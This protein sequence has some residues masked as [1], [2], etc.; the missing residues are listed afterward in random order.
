MWRVAEPM[1]IF[2]NSRSGCSTCKAKR[3]KCDE[4]KPTCKQCVKRKVTCG[5]YKKD[6]KWRAF[7]DASP[8]APSPNTH[9]KKGGWSQRGESDSIASP[10]SSDHTNPNTRSS[11]PW[12]CQSILKS[13][14]LS[15]EL[16]FPTPDQLL[17]DTRKIKLESFEDVEMSLIDAK[18]VTEISSS[19]KIVTPRPPLKS[20]LVQH[21]IYD[22]NPKIKE[23]EIQEIPRQDMTGGPSIP[24][25]ILSSSSSSGSSSH[26]LSSVLNQPRL[27]LN[28]P[29]M[30]ALN[31][32]R[33]TCGILSVK[34]G[35]SENPWRTLVWPMAKVSPALYHAISSLSAFHCS[36]SNHQMKLAGLNHMSQSIHQL[37]K[38][39]NSMSIE[40]S[41]ATSMALALA[42]TWDTSISTGIEHVRGGSVLIGNALNKMKRYQST[43]TSTLRFLCKTWLYM[44]VISRLTSTQIDDLDVDCPLWSQIDLLTNN[45]EIDPLLG[46]AS[47]LFPIIGRIANLV[48]KVRKTAQNSISLISKANELKQELMNWS[49]PSYLQ[50]PEDPTC[51]IQHSIQT[52]EAY[53]WATMLYLHQAVPEI[54]SRS[55]EILAQ[56][57]LLRL[58]TVPVQSRIVIVHIYPLLAASCEAIALDDR[59]WVLERWSQM[60]RRMRISNIDRCIEVVKEVWCR[61]DQAQIRDQQ[62]QQDMKCLSTSMMEQRIVR[63]GHETLQNLPYE[64]T[65]RGRQHWAGIMKELKWEG[66]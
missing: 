61:R 6:F 27:A 48:S 42:D 28:S 45:D 34:D 33:N 54:P 1:Y 39:I 60:Q 7:S 58:A 43:D 9:N 12:K 11:T 59:I 66:E 24:S 47:T 14:I 40:V 41:L 25:Y 13:S 10:P 56:K 63:D 64:R 16:T 21:R 22:T 19:G 53:Q 15:S 31:F 50:K 20:V 38:N 26:D 44:D 62:R 51:D 35:V 46:C 29:E 18:A 52:A 32:D 5:G 49:P 17:E 57:V 23:E 2:A 30:L 55:A 37:Y 4:S 3:L 8:R 36:V 65:V